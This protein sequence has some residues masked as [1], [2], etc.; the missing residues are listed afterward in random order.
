MIKLL[1]YSLLLQK[2]MV[3]ELCI[4]LLF[5]RSLDLREAALIYKINKNLLSKAIILIMVL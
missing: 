1:N 2:E 5:Q 4:L 3:D